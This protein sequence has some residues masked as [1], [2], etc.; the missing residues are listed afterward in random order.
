MPILYYKPTCF[1]CQ[2]VIKTATK[3]G[4][5][6]ELKNVKS[7]AAAASELMERGGK[8]QVPFLV[9]EDRGVSMYE[10]NDII[11][12]LEQNYVH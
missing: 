10:S 7:D 5:P 11:N 9:D 2:S 6:L 12:Y 4:I 1:Y 8:R 3:L